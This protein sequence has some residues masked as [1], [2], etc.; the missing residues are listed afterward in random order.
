MPALGTSLSSGCREAG[1][2]GHGGQQMVTLQRE[3]MTSQ[4]VVLLKRQ[5]GCAGET[6]GRCAVTAP[7]VGCRRPWLVRCLQLVMLAGARAVNT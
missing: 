7:C 6:R 1:G 5:D 4:A 2:K 3:P